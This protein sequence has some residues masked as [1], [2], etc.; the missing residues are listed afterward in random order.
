MISYYSVS[1][2]CNMNS[3]LFEDVHTP[4]LGYFMQFIPAGNGVKVGKKLVG[5]K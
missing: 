3:Y 2:L 5:T 4:W 1:E